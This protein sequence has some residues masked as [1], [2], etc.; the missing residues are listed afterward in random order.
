MNGRAWSRRDLLRNSGW[1]AGVAL[2]GGSAHALQLPEPPPAPW[3]EP[4]RPVTVVVIGAGGRGNAYAGYAAKAPGELQVVG[5]AEPVRHRNEQMSSAHSVPDRN[6]FATWQHVFDRPRF[7]DACLI[8]TPDHLH[9]GPAMAALD[10]GY[11]LLIEKAIAPTWN[12]CREILKLA[13]RREAI[14]GVGHVLRYS[15]YFRML[16]HVV[17]SGRLGEL[18]SIQHLEPVEHIHM[19]HSFVRGNWG[20]ERKSTPMLLSKSC[21]DL[22]LLRWIV[23]R[24]CRRVTSFGSLKVFRPEMAPDGATARCT[25]G[26]PAESRCPY[27]ALDIYLRKKGWL[28]QK[29]TPG[30]D[31]ASTLEWLRRSDYGRCVYR[32]DNDVVDHQVVNLEFEGGVT[33]AFSMEG[34]TSYAGRRTRIFGS[35]GDLSGDERTLEV[36]SFRE[37]QRY[38]WSIDDAVTGSGHGGGDHGLAR[39]FVQAVSQ[40]DE[41]LLSSR[42]SESMESHLVGFLAEASRREGGAVKSVDLAGELA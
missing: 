22:D 12:Q 19:S 15:P 42:L 38:R 28:T 32:H 34:L 1:V 10:L 8:T 29:D 4:E 6:R 14:V 17:H 33:A 36:S 24:P 2:S 35:E 3:K 18:V 23:D 7:A 21:H 20:N 27:S 37:G 39:D 30:R 40:R 5:V 16:R 13:A 25:D 26:C 31:D 9:F 11:H 41:S